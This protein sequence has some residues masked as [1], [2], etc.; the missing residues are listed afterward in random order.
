[1]NKEKI[2]K[3]NI[4]LYNRFKTH[5]LDDDWR[6]YGQMNHF[7]CVRCGEY[8]T[9]GEFQFCGLNPK[10]VECW[11]CQHSGRQEEDIKDNKQ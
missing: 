1:M 4:E 6:F 11:K 9:Q 2:I 3:E 8:A 7:K 10:E 5:I